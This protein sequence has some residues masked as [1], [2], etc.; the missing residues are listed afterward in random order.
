MFL[1]VAVCVGLIGLL[2]VEIHAL[3]V[4][5]SSDIVLK[6]FWIDVVIGLTI[7]LKTSIDFVIYIGN[8]MSKNS[9]WKSRVAIEIGTA[10]GNSAG[11]MAILLVWTFFKEIRWLLALMITLAALVLFK[12]A[13]GGLEHAKVEDALYPRWFKKMVSVFE[14]ILDRVNFFIAPVLKYILPD[15]RMKDGEPLRFW[16]LFALSFTIP[17]ILGLDDFAGYVPLFSIINVFGFAIGVFSG[18][19]ILNIFLYISPSRTIRAVKNPVI[20]FL[21]SVA[22]VGLGVWGLVEVARLIG[23]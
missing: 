3:N 17:F 15:L 2:W 8:L 20:S 16:P 13:E 19:M 21:G 12:L 14:R 18:H 1:T 7:Y 10:L 9:G 5:T 23:I 22:F 6:V 4:V 11:T